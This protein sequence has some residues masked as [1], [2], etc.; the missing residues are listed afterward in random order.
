VDVAYS[1][2]QDLSVFTGNNNLGGNA[3]PNP[4]LIGV[5][6]GT[7]S[8]NATYDPQ[9]RLTTLYHAGA[10][11]S[12]GELVGKMVNPDIT[13]RLHAVIVDNTTDQIL[14]WGDFTDVAGN[15]DIYR[16]YGLAIHAAL[17]NA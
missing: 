9:T 10:G 17:H 16:L 2:V 1:F 7:W 13:Q 5:T 15:L 14:V 4:W 6:T 3:N 12:P 11:W 8:A